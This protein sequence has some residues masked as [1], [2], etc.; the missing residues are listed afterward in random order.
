MSARVRVLCSACSPPPRGAW[1]RPP[2]PPPNPAQHPTPLLP[3]P[4]HL[5]VGPFL[6]HVLHCLAQHRVDVVRHLPRRL[7]AARHSDVDACS[8][9]LEH[10]RGRARLAH[11]EGRG[12]GKV[13]VCLGL[14]ARACVCACVRACMHQPPAARCNLAGS[15]CRFPPPRDRGL[16]MARVSAHPALS[17]Q[18]HSLHP[19]TTPQPT[20]RRRCNQKRTRARTWPGKS[21]TL[22]STGMGCFF[23]LKKLLPMSLGREGRMRSSARNR[24]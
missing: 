18:Q 17:A 20:R 1:C 2:P 15:L 14:C 23:L 3:S 9:V 16:L 21:F 10:V 11:L 12:G 22:M 8:A 19:A 5:D 24:S 13:H 4:P 6:G 7:A